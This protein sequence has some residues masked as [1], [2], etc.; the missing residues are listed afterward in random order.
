M[1][2]LGGIT[3]EGVDIVRSML[4]QLTANASMTAAF[5]IPNYVDIAANMST[6]ASMIGTVSKP[7]HGLAAAI[8]A[9]TSLNA[10]PRVIRTLA[11]FIATS[12][13][14]QGLLDGTLPEPVIGNVRN[15]YLV[16][17]VKKRNR[18]NVLE[19]SDLSN[20]AIDVEFVSRNNPITYAVSLALT[21]VAGEPVDEDWF[22]AEWTDDSPQLRGRKYFCTARGVVGPLEV[23]TYQLWIKVTGVIDEPVK[24]AGTI[25][26]K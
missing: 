26:V 19:V 18:M 7:V 12:V 14:T 13:T 5:T 1:S 24:K 17:Y 16:S 25:V 6:A 4:A 2:T 22:N 10:Q 8:A 15:V 3:P 20:E 11:G 23:G 21:S 9:D